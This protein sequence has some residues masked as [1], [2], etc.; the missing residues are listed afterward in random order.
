[1]LW[2]LFFYKGSYKNSNKEY[3]KTL[4]DLKKILDYFSSALSRG[5]NTSRD[6]EAAF[7][8]Q[9]KWKWYDTCKPMYIYVKWVQWN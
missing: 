8:A 3:Y 7:L 9:I 6:E 1:M 4:Q 5:I 2:T